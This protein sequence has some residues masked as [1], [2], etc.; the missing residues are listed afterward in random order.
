VA[1]RWADMPDGEAVSN[2]IQEMLVT[3]L[4]IA[5]TEAAC[6]HAIIGAHERWSFNRALN[7]LVEQ[8]GDCR[9]IRIDD[10]DG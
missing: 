6:G 5:E 2:I 1:R 8:Y 7:A 4:E 10:R 3:Q 9:V